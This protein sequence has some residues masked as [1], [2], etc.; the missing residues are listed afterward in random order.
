MICITVHK[1][2]TNVSVGMCLDC[3]AKV[4]SLGMFRSAK[5]FSFLK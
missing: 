1:K 3:T 4:R 5:D 2:Q